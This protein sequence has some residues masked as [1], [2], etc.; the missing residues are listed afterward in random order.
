MAKEI[1]I[2][3]DIKADAKRLYPPTLRS[4]R[5][6]RYSLFEFTNSKYLENVSSD[7]ANSLEYLL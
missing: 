7:K 6:G 2:P 4:K 3:K 5:N 1:K